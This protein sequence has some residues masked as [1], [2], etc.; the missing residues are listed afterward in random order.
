MQSPTRI[1]KGRPPQTTRTAIKWK[2]NSIIAIVLIIQHIHEF[3]KYKIIIPSLFSAYAPKP[4]AISK[5]IL[6]LIDNDY[7]MIE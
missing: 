4:I 2:N 6:V 3:S 7:G 1:L 5:M